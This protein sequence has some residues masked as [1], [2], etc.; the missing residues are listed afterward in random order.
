MQNDHPN[1]QPGK[2]PHRLEYCGPKTA[3]LTPRTD[4]SGTADFFTG[5]LLLSGISIL[6]TLFEP[7][8]FV[9]F[10]LPV[11]AYIVVFHLGLTLIG[12][13][14]FWIMSPLSKITWGRKSPPNRLIIRYLLAPFYVLG[15][16]ALLIRIDRRNGTEWTPFLGAWIVIFPLLAGVLA[17]RESEPY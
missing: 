6:A 12:C 2:S 13:S 3:N 4:E 9:E 8:D 7:H 14:C 5:T 1:E 15:F 16:H 10:P 17:P 11:I